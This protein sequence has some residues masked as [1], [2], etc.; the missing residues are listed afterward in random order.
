MLVV[1]LLSCVLF[2]LSVELNS[3]KK[4]GCYCHLN[5]SGSLSYTAKIHLLLRC[6]SSNH[7]ST[8]LFNFTHPAEQMIR[9]RVYPLLDEFRRCNH[10]T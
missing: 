9:Y 7:L 2:S 4:N 5:L 8:R 3:F 6:L 10:H 1:A